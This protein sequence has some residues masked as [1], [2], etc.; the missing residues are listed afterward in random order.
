MFK[1]HRRNRKNEA[2]R[3]L[4]GETALSITDFIAP[5]F[6]TDRKQVL[7]PIPHLPGIFRYSLDQLLLY[8]ESIHSKGINA[9][10]LF[11]QIDPNLKCSQG[12]ES[13]NPSGIIPLAIQ[14]IKKNFP[15]LL[16]ISD[17]ALDPYTSH[18]HDGL[19]NSEGEIL[20]D[21]TIAV[22]IKQALTHAEAGADI[23]APSDMMDGRISLIRKALDENGYFGIN[24]LSYC[25]KYASSFYGPFRSA[26]QTKLGFGDKKTYQMDPANFREALLEAQSDETEGAD[27]LMIKPALPYLD[28]IA[29]IK[30]QTKLPVGAYHVSGEYA[31]VVAASR[32]G[33]LDE[34]KAMIEQL[35]CIKRA[36]AQFIYTYAIPHVLRYFEQMQQTDPLEKTLTQSL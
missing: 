14:E 5:L 17:I 24:L 20:N 8:I 27:M 23:L 18:G 13:W 32:Q 11:P 12:N 29:G 28:V 19:C 33:M 31:M 1:R 4:A 22:L 36:G 35:L 21:E 9:I 2:M 10:S 16:I 25:A 34:Q 15:N 30:N 26:I 6:I 3:M 7:E